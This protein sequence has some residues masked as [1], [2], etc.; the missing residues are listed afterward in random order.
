MLCVP[1]VAEVMDYLVVTL[2]VQLFGRSLRAKETIAA[3]DIVF[4]EMAWK[5][6]HCSPMN[7]ASIMVCYESKIK[8]FL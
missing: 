5:W 7:T 3:K 8:L 2:E 6:F 4:V 1:I